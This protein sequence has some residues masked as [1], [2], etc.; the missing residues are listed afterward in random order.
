[1]RYGRG[2]SERWP[3]A[4]LVRALRGRTVI[5]AFCDGQGMDDV[6]LRLDDGTVV[7]LDATVEE[8]VEPLELGPRG[9][10]TVSIGGIELWR[11]AEDAAS[12]EPRA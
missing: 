12:A 1:M 6:R 5:D 2:M 9:R 10:L 3:A 8:I 4:A 11:G 7:A